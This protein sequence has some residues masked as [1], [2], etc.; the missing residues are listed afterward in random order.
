LKSFRQIASGDT[1]SALVVIFIKLT[2]LL[3]LAEPPKSQLK[4]K[5]ILGLGCEVS[6]L[7]NCLKE[8][9]FNTF[10][11]FLLYHFFNFSGSFSAHE[12]RP[13]SSLLRC[14][15]FNFAEKII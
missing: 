6:R 4:Y 10:K 5:V 8:Q 7:G 3:F 9:L 2:P 12:V 11:V 15:G 1:Q 13:L 14:L